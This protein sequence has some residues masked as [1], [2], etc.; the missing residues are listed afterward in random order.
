MPR[1][2]DLI[3]SVLPLLLDP[4]EDGAGAEAVAQPLAQSPGGRGGPQGAR[5]V[6]AATLLVVDAAERTERVLHI[7]VILWDFKFSALCTFRFRDY[8]SH[9]RDQLVSHVCLG[10]DL[11]S[12]LRGQIAREG[13]TKQRKEGK[14][15]R[16]ELEKFCYKQ[17]PNATIFQLYFTD[18]TI[19]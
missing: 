13:T 9:L 14:T 15:F 16:A 19:I 12:W 18:L 3:L 5:D 10:R 1:P 11:R 8:R 6:T 7:F 17:K 2:T 4:G